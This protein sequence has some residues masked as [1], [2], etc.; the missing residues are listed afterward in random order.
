MSL[1]KVKVKFSLDQAMK[2]QAGS[3]AVL[4]SLTSALDVGAFPTPRPGR[5][6]PGET[7]NLSY[8][9]VGGQQRRS[10]R[11]RKNSPQPRCDTRTVASRYT[12]YA[13]ASENKEEINSDQTLIHIPAM[14]PCS[15][16]PPQKKGTSGPV[17]PNQGSAEHRSGFCEERWNKLH[18][19]FDTSR[20]TPNIPRNTGKCYNFLT[21]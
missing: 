12:D 18:I 10:G 4:Y 1:Y 20:K 2:P 5:L 11:V 17:L 14:F 8:R 9:R 21:V 16:P 19:N 15:P 6:T 13:I 3:R 7:R